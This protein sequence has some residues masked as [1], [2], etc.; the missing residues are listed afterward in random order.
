MRRITSI[1][2]IAGLAVAASVGAS[3]VFG[4]GE[5]Q[6]APAP[7]ATTVRV[8]SAPATLNG[9]ATL[10]AMQA[11]FRDVAATALPVVVKIDTTTVVRGRSR[12]LFS[13]PG[14]P[15]EFEQPGGTGSG[16]IVSRDGGDYFVL[17]NNHVIENTSSITLTLDDGQEFEG[18]LV[19]RDPRQ[20]LALVSFKSR[21][22]LPVAELGD[23]TALRVGDW[24]LAVGSPFG[25][26]STVTTGIVSALGRETSGSLGGNIAEYIQTDAAINPGN[27][28][29]AL[30]NLD[31]QVV[32]INTWITS[33]GGGNVG[34]GFALP[35]NSAK[36][37]IEDF[38][39]H[40]EVRYGYLGAFV[41]EAGEEI[42][43]ALDVE[44]QLG[45]IAWSIILQS[46]AARG[47]LRPGDFVTRVNGEAVESSAELIRAVGS[48]Q[49]NTDATFD[50]IRDGREQTVAVRVSLRDDSDASAQDWPGIL[51]AELTDVARTQLGVDRSVQGVVVRS[52]TD[53]SPT[54]EAGLR[55]GD[56]LTRVNGTQLRDI[57]DFYREFGTLE[58]GDYDIEVLRQG[59]RR[60]VEV[61]L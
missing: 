1:V 46:P 37:A 41:A 59:E 10:Q 55:P 7:G 5:R 8:Q 28:G 44:D 48:L 16:V 3:G 6:A 21:G 54:A 35:I 58:R 60:T 36:R 2:L 38:K 33:R 30:V 51:P 11:S 26:Q 13:S 31:G 12:G 24:V 29:G 32:G 27:S 50:V 49:P 19:G 56:V 57:R 9:L 40:G 47:D 23:S 25:F 4:D 39:Q 14:Q 45:A 18:T 52:V 43:E 61:T 53:R 15:R 34:L 22:Q 42:R 17:T 20:D